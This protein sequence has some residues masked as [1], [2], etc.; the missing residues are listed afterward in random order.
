MTNIDFKKFIQKY[1]NKLNIIQE[2]PILI[3]INTILIYDLN[4]FLFG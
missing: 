3:E 2:K 4:I 1:L